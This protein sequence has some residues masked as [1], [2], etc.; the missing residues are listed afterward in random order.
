MAELINLMA[1]Q[2]MKEKP[3]NERSETVANEREATC[4]WQFVVVDDE[5]N[6]WGTNLEDDVKAVLEKGGRAIEVF[7]DGG[8]AQLDSDFNVSEVTAL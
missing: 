8:V 2:R 3:Q 7:P 5:G 4:T 6:I 1:L